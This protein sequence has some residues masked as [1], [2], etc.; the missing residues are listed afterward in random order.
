M[1]ARMPLSSNVTVYRVYSANGY[2]GLA[3]LTM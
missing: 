3:P 1:Q 2:T